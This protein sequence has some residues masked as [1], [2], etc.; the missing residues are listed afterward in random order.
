CNIVAVTESDEMKQFKEF[1]E[2]YN[3]CTE[4][5]VYDISGLSPS[6]DEALIAGAGLAGQLRV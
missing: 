1:L 2:T 3:K 4:T 6:V 5:S